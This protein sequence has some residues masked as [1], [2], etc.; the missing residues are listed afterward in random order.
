M[1][2]PQKENGYVPIANHIYDAFRAIRIPGEARQILDCIIRQT[3]GYNKLEDR[4]ALVQFCE[5]TGMKKPEVC[6]ALA[7]LQMMNIIVG[8][9]ANRRD[10]AT[11][12]SFNKNYDN[13]VPLAKK[14]KLVGEKANG[15]IKKPLQNIELSLA[16]KPPSKDILKY[17]IQ[18]TRELTPAKNAII[19]FKG[20]DDLLNKIESNEAGNT[21]LFLQQI[22]AKYQGAKK[23][24]IWRE[25][26]KFHSYWTE[27]NGTG[28]KQRWQKQ[29]AFQ[30]DRR[31][32]T[33]FGKVNEFK[34]VDIKSNNKYQVGS[35]QKKKQ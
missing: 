22:E 18:K 35:V 5:W 31:L 24:V 21:K 25:I 32:V 9:K 30:V 16:K 34:E 27:L 8:K 7:K 26:K 14:Q 15:K 3:Y 10:I 23:D 19:F 12:Y 11:K 17:N 29:D 28:T 1:A 4:I 2:N 13:W 33:W 20:I 6:R